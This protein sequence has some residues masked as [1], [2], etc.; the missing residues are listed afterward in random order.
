M[1][2]IKIVDRGWNGY[3][4]WLNGDSCRWEGGRTAAEAIAKLRVS[5]PEAK[6]YPVQ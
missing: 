3:Q 2:F 6:T 1:N 5:F 4:A